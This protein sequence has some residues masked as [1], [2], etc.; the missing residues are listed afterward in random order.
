VRFRGPAASETDDQPNPF[1]DYRLQVA[2]TGPSGQQSGQQYNVAGYFDGDG[3]DVWPWVG[4]PDPNGS[5]E[6]DNLHYDIGKL[7][8]WE[9]VFAHAQRKGIFLHFVFNEAEKPNKRELD[10]GELGTERKL[11]Y[12][13]LIARCGHHLALEWNLCEEYNLGFDLG[14]DRVRSFAK[15][16]RAVDPYDHPVTVHSAGDPLK[17]LQFTFGD[18]L[19]SLTSIQLGQ[20]KI[21]SL[22]EQFREATAQ[23]GRPLPVSMDEFTLDKG[24]ERGWIPVDDA[25]RWRTEKLWPTYL[26]GGN[27]E[28]ILGDLL[29]TDSFKTLER[30]KLW[31]YVWHARRFLEALPFWEMKPADQLVTGACTISVTQNRGRKTYFM[32]AQVFSQP[33]EVYAIYLPRAQDGA[34]LDLSGTEQCFQ[35]RWYNPRTGQFEGPAVNVT[36]GARISLGKPPREVGAD[37]ALLLE[38]AASP[39]GRVEK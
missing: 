6:N 11:Y 34:T 33:G 14:P 31:T 9:T 1:L 37:W 39:R 4:S 26:S 13:E 7:R 17:A 23:A 28:F 27:I 29:E 16:V 3:K 18:P 22:T 10:D 21:D 32:G 30:E 5:P 15:Y 20:H 19:F 38:R 8:Q 25:E 12:R 24:Q 35:Q 36:G 2:F